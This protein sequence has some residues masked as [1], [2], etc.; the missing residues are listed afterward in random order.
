MYLLFSDQHL[1]DVYEVNT[2]LSNANLT[3]SDVLEFSI[4]DD[5]MFAVKDHVSLV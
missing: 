1:S 4:S 3:Q 2:N 5:Y